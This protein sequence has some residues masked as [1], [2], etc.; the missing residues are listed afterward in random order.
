VENTKEFYLKVGVNIRK[1]R[2]EKGIKQTDLAYD[3]DVPHRQVM[4]RIEKGG[5]NLTL[6][7]LCKLAAALGTTP[8]DL[9]DVD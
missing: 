6:K 5:V 9:I 7:T 2:L 8:S 1:K 3:I 4:F